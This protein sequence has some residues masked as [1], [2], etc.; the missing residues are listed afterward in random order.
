MAKEVK[1]KVVIKVTDDGSLKKTK[2][3][4][5]ALNKST[6]RASQS[7]REY[8]RNMKGASKQSS[9]ASKNFS[10]QAQ[11][12]WRSM[13]TETVL[14]APGKPPVHLRLAS[15]NRYRMP[16]AVIARGISLSPNSYSER[17]RAELRN[18][19]PT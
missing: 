3:E 19:G 13:Q 7:S 6:G 5:D 14:L 9:N 12:M 8:D 17:K 11:G 2:K 1:K 15:R 18:R 4:I 16:L 10:K